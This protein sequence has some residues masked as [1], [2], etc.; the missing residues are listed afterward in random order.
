MPGIAV[1]GKT[2]NLVS[3]LAEGIRQLDRKAI[4][5]SACIA[6]HQDARKSELGARL[7]VTTHGRAGSDRLLGLRVPHFERGRR[8]GDL[9]GHTNP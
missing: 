7:T 5:K 3:C 4:A 1:A 2:H 9:F 8:R 6:I